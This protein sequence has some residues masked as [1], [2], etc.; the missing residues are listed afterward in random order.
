MITVPFKDSR[1]RDISDERIWL[2]TSYVIRN[3][4]EMVR[5]TEQ[6][7]PCEETNTFIPL[8]LEAEG[9]DLEDR[10]EEHEDRAERDGARGEVG[11]G[12]VA[13][14]PNEIEMTATNDTFDT[15]R[16]HTMSECPSENN[17][18]IRIKPCSKFYNNTYFSVSKPVVPLDLHT[19]KVLGKKLSSVKKKMGGEMPSIYFL[20]RLRA[21]KMYETGVFLNYMT[22]E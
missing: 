3:L 11:H 20:K 19:N 18:A 6:L 9:G 14:R 21:V 5:Q 1:G 13:A 4:K 8:H 22:N 16:S 2:Y 10:G 7:T 15:F 17:F 12:V